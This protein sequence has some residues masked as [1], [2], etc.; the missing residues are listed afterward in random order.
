MTPFIGTFHPFQPFQPLM[1][2][3]RKRGSGPAEMGRRTL[4]GRCMASSKVAL[5]GWHRLEGWNVQSSTGDA[6]NRSI[7]SSMNRSKESRPG[8]CDAAE[9]RVAW[10]THRRAVAAHLRDGCPATHHRPDTRAGV[11]S[12]RDRRAGQAEPAPRRAGGPRV[13]GCRPSG[14]DREREAAGPT[15]AG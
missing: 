11:R 9:R 3:Y 15:Q 7:F 6:L 1:K 5:G 13:G 2:R 8:L 4:R 10:R 14:Q 12:A